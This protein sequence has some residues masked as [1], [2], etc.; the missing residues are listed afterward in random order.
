MTTLPLFAYIGEQGKEGEGK[1]R[2]GENR[3]ITIIS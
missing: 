2:E 1:K 3:K